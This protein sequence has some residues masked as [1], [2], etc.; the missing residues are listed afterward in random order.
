MIFNEIYGCY[1][2]AVAKML[3]L[4]VDGRLDEK[5][6]N[7]IASEYAFE[8]SLL[9]I[10]P[11]LKNQDW[12]LIDQDYETPILHK[13]TMPMTSLEKRWLRTI[14]QD[15]RIALFQIPM[16]E[17]EEVEPLFAPEDVVYF[18]RYLDGDPY[19]QPQ[20]VEIFTT[21]RQ[22]I[23]EHRKVRIRFLSGKNKERCYVLDPIKL[24]YSD[25]EDKFRVL[26]AGHRDTHTINLGRI[27]QCTMLEKNFPAEE[28]LQPRKRETLLFELTD[29]RNALERVM[30]QFAHHKKEVERVEGNLYRVELEYDVDDETDVVIQMMSFGSLV[31]IISPDYMKEELRNRITKQLAMLEW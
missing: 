17:L 3:S 19:D 10:V 26:C 30:M 31:Q 16:G 29:E 18:D 9:T 23:Q 21:L 28:Q 14:L 27:Q 13:P 1:Y 24:E 22:A 8:E 20:Y 5:K 15:P 4:A 12:Q 25:K 6:M 2:N 7:R 11:A